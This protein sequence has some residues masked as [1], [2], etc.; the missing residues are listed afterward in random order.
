MPEDS[1]PPSNTPRRHRP[2]LTE[3]AKETTEDDLWVLDDD[4]PV[5]TPAQIT[6]KPIVE[7]R[8]PAKEEDDEES[9]EQTD[10]VEPTLE[11]PK[12][13]KP[14]LEPRPAPKAEPTTESDL[15]IPS[16]PETEPVSAPAPAPAEEAKNTPEPPSEPSRKSAP[17]IQPDR[18]EWIG[19]ALL[20]VVCLGVAIWWI[21]GLFSSITTT[22][23]GDDEPDFPVKGGLIQVRT[24]DS[25]WR[26]PIR[27]GENADVARADV[28]QIPVAE[29]TLEGQGNGVLRAI[30]R[31]DQGEFVGDSITRSFT[32]GHFDLTGS[33]TAQF[34]ATSGFTE[35]AAFNA[36]RVGGNR[37]TVEVF[38]G[39]S[40]NAPGSEFKLLFKAPISSLRR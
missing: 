20:G 2:R 3:L 38:E 37:W 30:F 24:A 26:K 1:K 22:R 40:D 16:E 4:E 31:D 13:T 15:E 14:P 28:V 36:Y 23:M 17:A 34:P 6:Q 25:F 35:D 7:P 18:K 39:P 9:P 12:S 27:G 29:V 8:R 32:S 5:E 10:R 19:L 11:V 21:A 33:P